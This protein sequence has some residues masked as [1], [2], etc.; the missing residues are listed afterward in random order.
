MVQFYP[1]MRFFIPLIIF[2]IPFRAF[3]HQKKKIVLN[4]LLKL[5]T[6]KSDFT[7]TLGYLNQTTNNSTM[8]FLLAS[9]NT[10]NSGPRCLVLMQLD[11]DHLRRL[12]LY[13]AQ[14][15]KVCCISPCCVITQRC[16]IRFYFWVQEKRSSE[17]IWRKKWS[18][19]I[20]VKLKR[21]SNSHCIWAL[22]LSFYPILVV[23]WINFKEWQTKY[24]NIILAKFS[25]SF[26]KIFSSF[27]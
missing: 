6:L 25:G 11:P 24:V 5:S 3:C 1:S 10:K 27:A 19:K 22:T 13:R 26:N 17:K 2:S 8:I 9:V 15:T 18:K 14:V 21:I 12:P 7:L 16:Q 4:F 20:Y 23:H